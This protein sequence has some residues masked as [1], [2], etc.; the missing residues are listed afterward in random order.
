MSGAPIV[1]VIHREVDEARFKLFDQKYKSANLDYKIVPAIDG[2]NTRELK[3]YLDLFPHNFWG[4]KMI[5]PGALGCFLSHREAWLQLVE[6]DARYMVIAEDDSRPIANFGKQWAHYDAQMQKMDFLFLNDRTA[7]WATP[8]FE[9]I[10]RA[11]FQDQ[12]SQVI[13]KAGR[14]PGADGYVLSR[15]F[16]EELLRLVDGHGIVCGVDYFMLGALWKIRE[17]YIPDLDEFRFIAKEFSSD[18]KTF[19]GKIS[20]KPLFKMS[21]GLGSAIRHS[22]TRDIAELRLELE[23][24]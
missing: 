11:I 12:K 18:P 17:N 16:A 21:R 1:H 8:R 14:A 19:K 9:T 4:G 22:E 15:R 5:K 24:R 6:S 13:S 3:P 7:D 23:R 2:H 10:D 20:R